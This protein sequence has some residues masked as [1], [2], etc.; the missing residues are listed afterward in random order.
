MYRVRMVIENAS[1]LSP[2]VGDA[3]DWFDLSGFFSEIWKITQHSSN[4]LDKFTFF[5]F[6]KRPQLSKQHQFYNFH[7]YGGY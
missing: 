5:N 6:K 3:K 1:Q 4:L 2:S 7:I